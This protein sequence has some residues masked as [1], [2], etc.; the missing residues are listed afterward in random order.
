V[1]G[2]VIRVLI[3]ARSPF[4][5]AGLEAALSADPR[6]EIVGKPGRT[7]DLA[8][9]IRNSKP[10]VAL[11]ETTEADTRHTLA[12]MSALRA[13]PALV[14]LTSVTERGDVHRLLRFGV[15]AI[16]PSDSSAGE[17]VDALQAANN[18]LTVLSQE[19]LDL[20]LP[21]PEKTD[22]ELQSFH[23]PLTSR[24]SEVLALLAEGAGN[25]EIA[26]NLGVS[27]HTAKFHVSSIMS[28]LG[29]TTRTEAVTR[30]YR[31]GLI[32]I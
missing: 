16:L 22:A 13:V 3:W 31:L 25:R 4:T 14:V 2:S 29:A 1:G 5:R 27:E 10:D 26:A 12:E 30:G 23:E 17:I 6:F 18:G 20:L 28:K 9:T 15:R 7:T 11:I 24:E 19:F 21:S 8:S 32:L